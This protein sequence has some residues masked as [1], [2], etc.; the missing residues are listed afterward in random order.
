M[1]NMNSIRSEVSMVVKMW[2]VVFWVKMTC[3]FVVGY[4]ILE[5]PIT[6]IFRVPEYEGNWLV[7]N[8]KITHHN[9][10]DHNSH[11]QQYSSQ[12]FNF[13]NHQIQHV[14]NGTVPDGY[15]N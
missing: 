2:S 15:Q 7:T 10:E 13:I 5:E 12:E 4:Q 6:S 1:E 14:F 11:G 3:S 8:H 9:P